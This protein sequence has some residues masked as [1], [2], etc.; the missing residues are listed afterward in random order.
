R[1]NAFLANLS[2]TTRTVDQQIG[3]Q[4]ARVCKLETEFKRSS[5]AIGQHLR[6]LAGVLAVGFSG[7]ELVGLVDSFTRL[8]NNLRVAGVEGDQLKEV[9]DR[10]FA[11]AQRYGVELETLSSLY[12]SL[13]QASSE[14]G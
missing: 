12:S 9:Q 1:T 8:Q 4:E 11:S 6:G 5:G 13:T 10:L 7:R 2:Q 14:L 3:R